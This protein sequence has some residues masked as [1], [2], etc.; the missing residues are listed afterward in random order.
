V[1]AHAGRVQDI[2]GMAQALSGR[3]EGK[4]L[5]EAFGRL[6]DVPVDD[7]LRDLLAM[8]EMVAAARVERLDEPDEILLQILLTGVELVVAA[9]LVQEAA[10]R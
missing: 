9:Q 1:T 2:L 6:L 7:D 3:A 5:E 8:V 10:R 4:P